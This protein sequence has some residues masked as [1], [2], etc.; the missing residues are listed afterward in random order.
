MMVATP[1]DWAAVDTMWPLALRLL[2][3]P[4]AS[5]V[6]LEPSTPVLALLDAPKLTSDVACWASSRQSSAPTTVSTRTG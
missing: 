4:A 5:S 1:L 2:T 6:V 3:S